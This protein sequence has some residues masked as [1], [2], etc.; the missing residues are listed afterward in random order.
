MN[1][2][3]IGPEGSGK[4]TI[5]RILSQKLGMEL[6]YASDEIISKAKDVSKFIKKHGMEKY[7]DMESEII[8]TISGHDD[9]IIDA[10]LNVILRNENIINLKNNG[11]LIIL[12]AHPKVI[13]SRMKGKSKSI[14]DYSKQAEIIESKYNKA[15][16]YTIDTSSMSPEEVS[17]LIVH[18]M[19]IELQ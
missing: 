10:E 3:L 2:V 11:I 14:F 5:S 1:I 19:G 17:E 8:E 6:I 7:H 4:T 18:Y 16:D 9:C 12:T 13:A 15:A